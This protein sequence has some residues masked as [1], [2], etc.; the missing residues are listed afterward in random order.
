LVEKLGHLFPHVITLRC[1]YI[2]HTHTCI[3]STTTDKQRFVVKH[4]NFIFVFRLMQEKYRQG[5][6]KVLANNNKQR[7]GA[8]LLFL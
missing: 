3:L 4:A 2:E 6:R 1:V 5:G 7:L 8:F